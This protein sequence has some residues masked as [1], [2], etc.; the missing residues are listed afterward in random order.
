MSL[1]TTTSV[2]WAGSR[3]SIDNVTNGWMTWQAGA[4]S[5]VPAWGTQYRAIYVPVGVPRRCIV[6]ELG[7]V[8][9]STGAGNVDVGIYNSAGVRLVSTGTQA[10]GTTTSIWTY[11]VTDTTIGPGLYYIALNLDTATD[12]VYG[13]TATAPTPMARGLLTETL[14]SITLPATA[15]WAYDQ[16]LAFVPLVNALLVTEIS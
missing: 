15:T 11:N 16:T 12:T 6:L 8:N 5:A 14:G 2:L 13:T 7:F 1:Q 10:K 4:S 9:A 3:H